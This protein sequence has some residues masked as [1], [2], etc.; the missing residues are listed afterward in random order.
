[1]TTAIRSILLYKT[2]GSMD[3]FY[4]LTITPDGDLFRLNYMNGPRGGSMKTKPKLAD[5]VTLEVANKEFDKVQKAKMKDGYTQSESGLSY[6]NSPDA[7]RVSGYR[8]MLPADLPKVGAQD[9]LRQLLAS[10][11]WVLQE[12]MDGENRP[13]LISGGQVQGTNKNGLFVNIP[14]AWQRYGVLGEVTLCGE[15]IGED[16]HVFDLAEPALTFEQR[17]AKLQALLARH[18]ELPGL[19]LVQAH[20]GARAKRAHFEAIDQSKGEGVVFKRRHGLFEAGKNSQSY[21]HKFW[22][23]MTCLVQE[24]NAQRSVALKAFDAQAHKWVSLGNVTI[25]ANH[26]VPAVG[27]RVEVRYLYQF[28]KGALCQPT[29]LGTRSDVAFDACTMDQ[30]TRIKR[31]G[32]P[33][34][35]DDETLSEQARQ[36]LAR[37]EFPQNLVTLQ[38]FLS[39]HQNEM[40]QV[41]AQ[42]S[43]GQFYMDKIQALAERVRLMPQTGDTDGQGEAA[44]VQ[45]RY[46]VGGWEWLV[47]EKDRGAPDDASPG[48]QDQAFGWVDLGQGLEPGYISLP[49]LIESNVEMDFYFEPKTLQ[50]HHEEQSRREAIAPSAQP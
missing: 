14:A 43:E 39:C 38:H 26:P 42:G 33:I 3:K 6:T 30:I 40:V 49:E 48:A 20:Q 34:D 10:D 44:V 16:Y 50:A 9:F 12:K 23:S 4:G 36:A 31:K 37:E 21:R 47:T 46:F 35:L 17:Y 5:A 8:P 1:M 27:A 13:L 29:Y 18:S 32:A 19:K 11:E 15:H 45:L 7:G 28:E 24:V 41:F 22:E 2:E 25:P